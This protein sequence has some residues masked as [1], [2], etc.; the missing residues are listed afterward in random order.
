MRPRNGLLL[1]ALAFA[2]ALSGCSGAKQVP[3]A[4]DLDQTLSLDPGQT[5]RLDDETLLTFSN[6]INDS[7]CPKGATCV[8]A[9]TATLRLN[10]RTR[11]AS[12]GEVEVLVVLNG[13]VAKDDSAGL[14]PVEA[15]GYLFTLLALQPEPI[16]GVSVLESNYR[17]TIHVQ[18]LVN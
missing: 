6:V 9:G 10:L 3:P 14:I 17:A 16:A 18:K 1:P 7:R 5:V 2:W 8:W 12:P 11:D 4:E 15:D 13:G